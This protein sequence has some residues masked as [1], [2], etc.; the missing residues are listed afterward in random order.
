MIAKQRGHHADMMCIS[1]DLPAALWAD[2]VHLVGDFNAWDPHSM[3]MDVREDG[4]HIEVE[5]PCG[6][7]YRFR[8]LIDD[9]NWLVD[10]QAD[11]FASGSYG[12][13][14]LVRI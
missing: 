9:Q 11:G 1:F 3:P 2:R 5:L 14:A 7:A 13:D 10:P 6:R 4:W 12:C 8:Y